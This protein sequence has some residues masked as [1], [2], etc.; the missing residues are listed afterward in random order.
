MPPGI[1]LRMRPRIERR[2]HTDRTADKADMLVMER[3]GP[4]ANHQPAINRAGLN[5]LYRVGPRT[6]RQRWGSAS[7]SS[8]RYEAAKDKFI[9]QCVNRIVATAAGKTSRKA[10]C[11]QRR[12]PVSPKAHAMA[13]TTIAPSAKGAPNTLISMADM[14]LAK[15]QARKMTATQ[16]ASSHSHHRNTPREEGSLA[17]PAGS[18]VISYR[19][20]RRPNRLNFPCVSSRFMSWLEESRTCESAHATR[21]GTRSSPSATAFGPYWR[22]AASAP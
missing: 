1:H 21:A 4:K 7:R 18:E 12:C 17:A 11:H 6:G 14:S 13:A 19:P 20:A 16:P 22:S 15:K 10:T 9:G 5:G 8:A 2:F 3:R